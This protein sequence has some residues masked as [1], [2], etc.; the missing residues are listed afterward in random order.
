MWGPFCKP[1]IWDVGILNKD[2]YL[3]FSLLFRVRV[4]SQS[5]YTLRELLHQPFGVHKNTKTESGVEQPL[6]TISF[7]Y[8]TINEGFV[9]VLQLK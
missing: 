9:Q 8:A 6:S 3:L 4:A 7:C 1:L 2:C 5:Y